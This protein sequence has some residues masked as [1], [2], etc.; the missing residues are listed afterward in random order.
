MLFVL[1]AILAGYHYSAVNASYEKEK[2]KVY[3]APEKPAYP[4]QSA[5]N[6]YISKEQD[7]VNSLRTDAEKG[8]G[9][10]SLSTTELYNQAVLF[11]RNPTAGAYYTNLMKDYERE[12]HQY[13]LDVEK[14]NAL[15]KPTFLSANLDY[16]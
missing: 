15:V 6:T 2:A 11:L 16:F 7:I 8:P 10:M 12:L 3:Q 9:T 1:A 5:L 14:Q 4:T 13:Q